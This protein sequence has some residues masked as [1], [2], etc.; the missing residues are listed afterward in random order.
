MFL[1]DTDICIFWLR[2]SSEAVVARLEAI[3]PRKLG[4]TAITVAELYYG[5][6]HSSRPDEN[7]ESTAELLDLLQAFAFN[8][9]AAMHYAE[10][11]QHLVSRGAMIGHMDLLN[12]AIARASGWTFVTNNTREFERVPGLQIENWTQ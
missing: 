10:I 11:K 3:D 4:V 8:T 6:R 9:A 12:A 2:Q 1:L 5:A 7:L